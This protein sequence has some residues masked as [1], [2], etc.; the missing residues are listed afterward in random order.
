[1]YMPTM[2]QVP[3]LTRLQLALREETWVAPGLTATSWTGGRARSP[4][5]TPPQATRSECTCPTDCV[6]DHENE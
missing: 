3:K 5:A 1:M 6:R 2:H 4:L